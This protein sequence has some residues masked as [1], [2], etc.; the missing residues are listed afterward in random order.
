[1]HSEFYNV[2]LDRIRYS[3]VW[4]DS[5]T[6]YTGLGIRPGDT[7]L[8]IT[9]AG[10]NAL[11]ALL[12][13]PRQ[14]VAID[15]N[16]VQNKLLALKRHVILHHEHEVLRGLMGL[17]GP[18]AVR[19]AWQQLERTLPVA[20]QKYWSAFFDCHPDGLLTAGR[21]EAYVTG[22]Y[23]TLAPSTQRKLRSLAG[24][25]D[26]DA[27]R[28][29]FRT[30]L[31]GSAFREQFVAYF[32][33]QNL[34]KGRDPRL[35]AYARESGG[36]AFYNRLVQQVS[37]TLVGQ[38]FFFR[39]LFF[40]PL[41]IPER[42][43]PPC[44]QRKHYRSLRAQLPKLTLVEGEAVDYLLSPEGAAVDK[45]SLSNIFEYTSRKEFEKACH[46]LFTERRRPLRF[47]FWNLLQEQGI[48]PGSAGYDLV[49]TTE[50]PAGA[51]SCFYF[52]NVRAL[53]SKP[54]R[55][56]LPLNVIPQATLS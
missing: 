10:C 42:I 20:L 30:E 6:L 17:D 53:E 51:H 14:V 31:D 1:M 21:L 13:N 37:T 35:F 9:S 15:L 18:V 44:Y 41:G 24:F 26:V 56:S 33:E 54:V 40:G 4:E 16:P 43:L 12:G 25:A 50:L 7:V 49:R 45:A 34:S 27:Q 32:D 52:R 46:L 8:V 22:F 23:A 39:F 48:C 11:N 2:A 47:L 55:A 5:T 29:Y 36:E 3:L 38:N 19:S 28:R